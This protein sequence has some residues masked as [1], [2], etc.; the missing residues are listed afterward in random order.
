[1]T[2]RHAIGFFR[3]KGLDIRTPLLGFA[4]IALCG[5]ASLASHEVQSLALK[6][7][8]S[9]NSVLENVRCALRNERGS[10]QASAPGN[11]VVQRSADTL[12]V[13][14]RRNGMKDGVLHVQA[15]AEAGGGFR[16]PD[17]L[18]VRMGET[19]GT[20]HEASVM[21]QERAATR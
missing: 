4:S 21:S 11:V 9:D 8:S 20:P 19:F 14:C 10:W 13:E 1:M 2:C 12:H 5:C 6:V 3:T 17:E 18:Q 16:Y 15:Q 7:R